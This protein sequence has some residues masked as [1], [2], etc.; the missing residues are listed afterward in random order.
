MAP[1]RPPGKEPA[2][3]DENFGKLYWRL[4]GST[5]FEDPWGLRHG[6]QIVS[7]WPQA[8]LWNRPGEAQEAQVEVHGASVGLQEAQ[9]KVQR[10]ML[11]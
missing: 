10:H 4:D 3:G 6:S 11:M 9:V 1:R 2:I 7:K 8:Q 5:I